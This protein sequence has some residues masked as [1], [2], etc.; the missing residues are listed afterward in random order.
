MRDP[1][2]RYS[3]GMG[4][5]DHNEGISGMMNRRSVLAGVAVVA[6]AGR[7]LGQAG[8]TRARVRGTIAAVA[9]DHLELILADGGKAMVALPADARMTW[10]VAAKPSDIAA[11]SYIG[12]VS[13]PLPDGT[14][15]AAEVQVFPPAMRGVGEGH[16]PW[17]LPGDSTMTNGTIGQMVVANGR[18]ITLTYKG[19][20][21]HVLVPDDVPFVTYVPA[22][23]SAL[24][25]G[26]HVLIN[27]TRAA[28]GAVTAAAVSI[29]KDGL[30][31]PM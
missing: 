28:D 1:I 30:V 27:G 26:A 9:A 5:S 17:D 21:Q 20:E 12:T 4:A 22:D 19:G 8:P 16:N 18:M 13:R 10:L 7:A 23:R 11:G 29:G 25:V 24:T 2:S 15:I 6:M 31:P 3:G 14:R